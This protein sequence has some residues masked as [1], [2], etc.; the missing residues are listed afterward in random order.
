M[1]EMAK[2]N[3]LNIYRYLI[4]LLEHRSSVE[5]SDDAFYRMLANLLRIPNCNLVGLLHVVE[6][7]KQKRAIEVAEQVEKSNY[8]VK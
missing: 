1:V 8:T 5:M 6:F 3:N 4:Y 7:G 2:A